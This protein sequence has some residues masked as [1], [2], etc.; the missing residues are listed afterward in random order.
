VIPDLGRVVERGALGLAHDVL[1]ILVRQLRITDRLLQLV[2]VALV[3]LRVVDFHGART[4]V[5][6]QCTVGIVEWLQ[7]ELHGGSLL[8]FADGN[9]FGSASD[10]TCV[11]VE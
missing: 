2:E 6:G 1:E 9:G 7:L 3:M 5:R 11:P 10:A 8:V 4:D